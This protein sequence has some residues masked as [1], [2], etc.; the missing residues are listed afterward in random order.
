MRERVSASP[1]LD[2]ARISRS[3]QL[4]QFMDPVYAVSRTTGTASGTDQ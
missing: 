2:G 1:P 4:R 3:R